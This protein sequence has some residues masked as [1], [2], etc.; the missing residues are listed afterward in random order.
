MLGSAQCVPDTVNFKNEG[1]PGQICPDSLSNG[2][3][4]IE[5]NEIITFYMPDSASVSD[6]GMELVKIRLDTV[7]DLPSGIQFISAKKE[8]YPD[9]AYCF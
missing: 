2:M 7:E 9:S 6:A 8:F 3:Q 4:G 5:Y 1:D